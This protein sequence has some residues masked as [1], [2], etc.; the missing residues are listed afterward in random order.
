MSIWKPTSGPE[1]PLGA[2]GEH[3]PQHAEL[4]PVPEV[5]LCQ[6]LRGQ[7]LN[8]LPYPCPLPPVM[9]T[10]WPWIPSGCWPG[11][12]D[13]F[14]SHNYFWRA[15]VARGPP[16]GVSAAAMH[17]ALATVWHRKPHRS[18]GVSHSTPMSSALPSECLPLVSRSAVGTL[19]FSLFKM[20]VIV[21]VLWISRIMFTG[22]EQVGCLRAICRVVN[23][24]QT[25]S[26]GSTPQVRH[27]WEYEPHSFFCFL[28]R[29]EGGG[30]ARCMT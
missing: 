6:R 10:S 27:S 22:K 15:F 21:I 24:F 18:R 5:L 8:Q 26:A 1:G 20:N 7:C 3:E 2:V 28:V 17:L 13:L 16:G 19:F 11:H 23:L 14:Q 12:M 29:T 9:G 25:W 30:D 4:R